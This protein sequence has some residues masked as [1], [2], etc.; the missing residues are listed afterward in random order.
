MYFRAVLFK[1]F[2]LCTTVTTQNMFM[3]HCHSTK[4]V[5]VPQGTENINGYIQ[6]M[7]LPGCFS[8]QLKHQC[9]GNIKFCSCYFCNLMQ[10]DDGEPT[11]ISEQ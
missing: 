11:F 4:Y 9:C 8:C 1:H 7:V 10:L 5:C 2:F 3:V 6:D